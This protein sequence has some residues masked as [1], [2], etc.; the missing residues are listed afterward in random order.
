NS[1]SICGI[2][3][4]SL[5]HMQG[6]FPH[7][8]E[9]GTFVQFGPQHE[10]TVYLRQYAMTRVTLPGTSLFLYPIVQLFF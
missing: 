8:D 4:L 10:N 1:W 3:I 2:V 5:I 7:V 9:L 6:T